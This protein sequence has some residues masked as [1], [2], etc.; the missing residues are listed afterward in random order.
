MSNAAKKHIIVPVLLGS[1]LL[2]GL[3]AGCA[4]EIVTKEQVDIVGVN[5][6]N[7]DVM[8]SHMRVPLPKKSRVIVATFV[9]NDEFTQTTT[10]GRMLGESAAA[11]LSQRGYNVIC[12][13]LRRN[14][15]VIN[16]Q[17]QFALSR[18]IRELS[19]NYNA[20]AVLVGTYTATQVSPRAYSTVD[21][22]KQVSKEVSRKGRNLKETIVVVPDSVYV[23]LRLVSADD[24]SLMA[25]HDFRMVMDEGVESL[26]KTTAG[27]ISYTGSSI[28]T[29]DMTGGYN[30]AYAV[31]S[32]VR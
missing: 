3:I 8:L 27:S 31:D 29:S 11:R 30:P 28:H 7:I 10:L 26:L 14:S 24:S 32:S 16:S 18:D 17:G 20:A 9:D 21:W 2:V 19:R 4:P 12:V 5:Y 25:A 23:S 15:F 6:D 1:I 13:N 22:M